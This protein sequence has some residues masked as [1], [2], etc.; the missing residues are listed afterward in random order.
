MDQSTGRTTTAR[1]ESLLAE[2]LRAEYD[3]DKP[4]REIEEDIA[5][6]RV[7]LSATIDAL[8]RELAPA[9]IVEKGADM[10]RTY[11]V[12]ATG[13]LRDRAWAYAIPSALIVVGL[14]WLMALR[15]RRW[16]TELPSEFAEMPAEVVELGET[17]M[18]TPAL[19]D[20]IEPVSMIDQK[21]TI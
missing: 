5:R 12:P 17:P 18:P 14:S 4:L 10:L 15:R 20:L 13:P 6:T 11:F 3:E 16:E 19:A 1:S 2:N 8:E 21:A 7:R 9:R